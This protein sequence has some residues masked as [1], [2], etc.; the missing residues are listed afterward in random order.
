MLLHAHLTVDQIA[1]ILRI[2]LMRAGDLKD[3]VRKEF[4]DAIA[5]VGILSTLTT[6]YSTQYQ[7]DLHPEVRFSF[8][9][10]RLSITVAFYLT[11]L[12]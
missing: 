8:I 5:I 3:N 10:H 1:S 9:I 6:L 2:S 4:L 11:S 12:F 7:F